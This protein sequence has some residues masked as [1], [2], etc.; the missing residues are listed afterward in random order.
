[1]SIEFIKQAN[2]TWTRGLGHLVQKELRVNVASPDLLSEAESFLRHIVQYLESGATLKHGETVSYGYWLTKFI[3]RDDFLDAWEYTADA[4]E[5]VPGATLAV[6]YWRDQHR[7]CAHWGASFEPPR[8]D[9]LIVVSS[10]VIE[11]DKDVQG[12]RYR[13]PEHMTGWWLTT[14]RFDGNVG[15][16]K[17]VHAYHVTAARPDLAHLVA[18]PHGYRFDLTYREDVWFDPSALTDNA[19]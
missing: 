4:T 7:T 18:L 2:S 15:S 19:S 16:L 1:V 17:T 13:S 3:E 12:V 5:F 6:T 11:G 8:P 9:R 10:G 14:G